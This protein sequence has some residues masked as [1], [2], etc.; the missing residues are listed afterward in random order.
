MPLACIVS[1]SD[2]P[3]ES[4]TELGEPIL[5]DI[6][7]AITDIDKNVKPVSHAA[8][9]LD[10]RSTIDS[11]DTTRG[12]HH[13]GVLSL[14]AG[15]W[16]GEQATAYLEFDGDS[17]AAVLADTSFELSSFRLRLEG[18]TSLGEGD[19]ANFSICLVAEKDTN[20]GY[21]GFSCDTTNGFSAG[22][23]TKSSDS[24]QL[25]IT[26]DSLLAAVR[27]SIL[28]Q[29]PLAIDTIIDSSVKD[30]P[31]TIYDTTFAGFAL[32]LGSDT[33][34]DFYSSFVSGSQPALRLRYRRLSSVDTVD[35]M[36]SDSLILT[37][38]RS[39]YTVADTNPAALDTQLVASGAT[40]RYTILSLDLTGFWDLF[41]D[42]VRGL[43]YHN[44]LAADIPIGIDTADARNT[45]TIN[46][47]YDLL[48]PDGSLADTSRMSRVVVSRD[49]AGAPFSLD[50]LKL[51]NIN[52]L[53][54]DRYATAYLYLV[55]SRY[56]GS[57][58]IHWKPTGTI[59]IRA[60]LSNPW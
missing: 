56:S 45:N 30:E 51:E 1:C 53:V 38:V 29:P 58:R 26:L 23:G 34:I 41:A 5:S 35:S 4:D 8:E 20:T 25:D 17:L 44:I 47:Y 28:A 60:V 54:E 59:P 40:G 32:T 9:V 33:L 39:D 46:V 14:K 36:V 50:S 10:G 7:P 43:E 49:S 16:W 42:T 52:R 19:S 57:A 18:V 13:S 37:C 31:D 12:G 3:F 55:V 11:S 27:D 2:S 21:A 48:G 24:S 22:G 15:P 6:D